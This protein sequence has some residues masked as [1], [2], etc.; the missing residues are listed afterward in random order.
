MGLTENLSPTIDRACIWH[1]EESG[2]QK[3]TESAGQRGRQSE[4]ESDTE[5]EFLTSVVSRQKVCNARQKTALTDTK[6]DTCGDQTAEIL[7]EGSSDC[8]DAEEE[9]EEGKVHRT[10]LLE[11][12]VR[13]HFDKN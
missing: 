2:R 7:D 11:E 13:G 6:H 1:L 5:D 4:E 10:N 9:N 8:D 3:A 12:E